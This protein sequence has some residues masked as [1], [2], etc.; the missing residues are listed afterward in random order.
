MW[1]FVLWFSKD[2]YVWY[3]WKGHLNNNGTV[4]VNNVTQSVSETIVQPADPSI[5]NVNWTAV[6]LNS[7]NWNDIIIDANWNIIWVNNMGWNTVVWNIAS[8]NNVNSNN[9]NVDRL[10]PQ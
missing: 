8:W 2:E 7:T 10:P 9:T 5:N 1:Y 3:T 6:N 4:S